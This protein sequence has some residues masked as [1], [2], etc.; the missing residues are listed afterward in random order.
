MRH[1]AEALKPYIIKLFRQL[2]KAEDARKL[3]YAKHDT[4]HL[5]MHALTAYIIR[6][7][8]R[9]PCMEQEAYAVPAVLS[10]L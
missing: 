1:S 6:M 8:Q 10:E 4:T 9:F 5:Q 2:A 3:L 7:E